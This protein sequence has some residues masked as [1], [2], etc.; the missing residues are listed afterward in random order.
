MAGDDPKTEQMTP[1]GPDPKGLPPTAASAPPPGVTGPVTG[2]PPE[3]SAVPTVESGT[4]TVADPSQTTSPAKGRNKPPRWLLPVAVIVVVAIGLGVG[5]PLAFAGSSSTT[6]KPG[7]SQTGTGTNVAG[8]YYTR[9]VVDSR[10]VYLR[11]KKLGAGFSGTLTVS[12][13][14]STK[15]VI[16]NTHYKVSATAN[17]SNLT[18]TVNPAVDGQTTLTGTFASSAITVTISPGETFVLQRG[19]FTAYRTLVTQ[20]TQTLL[21]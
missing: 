7:N 15:K 12:A 1:E 16:E 11:L 14:D 4:T 5:L 13:A 21:G 10:L 8:G 17:G 6:T 2:P 3:S 19:K 9:K 20:E 18:F